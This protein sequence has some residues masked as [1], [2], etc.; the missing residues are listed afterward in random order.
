MSAARQLA[1]WALSLTLDDIPEAARHAA[2]RHLT[3]G[4]GCALAAHRLG[5]VEPALTVARRYT[6][7]AE[8]TIL[9]SGERVAAPY[10]ALANGAL[11]HGLDF[12][13]THADALVHA[14]AAVLPA[15]LAAGE[16]T[17]AT[18]SELLVAAI[19]GYEV[20]LRLGAA[21]PHGFHAKGFH[22][23]SVCGVF[24]AAVVAARLHGLTEAQTVD[25]LGI[26]GSLAAGSLEFLDSD[27]STKQL[28]PGFAAQ[29]ALT[30]VELAAAGARGP[31]TILDGRYGLFASYLG[32]RVPASR[33]TRGLGEVWEVERITLK[34]YPV[35][36][37]SH[38]ALDAV[39]ALRPQLDLDAI[40]SVTVRVPEASVPIVCEPR[41]TKVT[42]STAYEAKFSIPW[43]VAAMVIDGEVTLDTFTDVTA[44][45][46]I[47]ALAAKVRCEG[48]G[49]DDA[50]ATAAGD[51]TVDVVAGRGLVGTAPAG[52]ALN[53]DELL[54]K[55]HSNAGPGH[56][57]TAHRWLRLGS[58]TA[59]DTT[60]EETVRAHV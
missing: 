11:V 26:A 7:P 46:D 35:C 10:A 49:Y 8:A 40:T 30:A 20:V 29:A 27:A 19:A 22:A 47:A 56:E 16:Q 57:A 52:R 3:D 12:D 44:R 43:C 59:A 9:G 23:T 14:T 32:N 18:D 53:D 36:Q 34:P 39:A 51:V 37:L 28:H 2:R 13:D 17:G 24:A 4:I 5:A 38:S 6:Q 45:P 55:F 54:A 58:A 42:P 60:T 25:A 33:L 21:V 41:R 31:A 50:P 15:L 1:A 48:Y